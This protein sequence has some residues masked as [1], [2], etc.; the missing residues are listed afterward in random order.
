MLAGAQDNERAGAQPPASVGAFQPGSAVTNK[1]SAARLQTEG[2]YQ[3]AGD[4]VPRRLAS[5]QNPESPGA[6]VNSPMSARLNV[7]IRLGAVLLSFH[8]INIF[9]LFSPL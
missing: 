5:K 3:K 7:S 4:P 1:Q 9:F 2:G 6:T 8:R